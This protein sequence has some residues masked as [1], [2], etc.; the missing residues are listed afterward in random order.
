MYESHANMS[1]VIMIPARHLRIVFSEWSA[2]TALLQVRHRMQG[3]LRP[4][5]IFRIYPMAVPTGFGHSQTRSCA[6]V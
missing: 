4:K 6:I 2:L 3:L 1:S 5:D